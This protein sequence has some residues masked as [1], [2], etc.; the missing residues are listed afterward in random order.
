MN[1]NCPNKPISRSSSVCL[2]PTT[3]N[4]KLFNVSATLLDAF[5][6]AIE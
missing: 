2:L 4:L 3:K 6:K 5:D 1:F